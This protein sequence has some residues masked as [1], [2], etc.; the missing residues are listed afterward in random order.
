LGTV[1]MTLELPVYG[2]TGGKLDYTDLNTAQLKAME[3]YR[4]LKA[5]PTR[6]TNNLKEAGAAW[7]SALG[8]FNP[9]DK[10]ARIQ[11]NLVADLTTNA[12]YALA[13]AQEWDRAQ[14]VLNRA[15]GWDLS[16]KE[17]EDLKEAADFL[18]DWKARFVRP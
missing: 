18:A 10:K 7:E 8:E 2:V 5:D 15:A 16:K 3:G 11:P 1:P 4:L 14:A 13:Y 9:L 6:A 17:R 12:A